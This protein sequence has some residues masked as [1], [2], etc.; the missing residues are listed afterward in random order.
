M[1]GDIPTYANVPKGMDHFTKTEF[2][3]TRQERK[4]QL[5]ALAF[6]YLKATLPDEYH[7]V[8]DMLQGAWLEYEEAATPEAQFMKGMDK[9]EC[10]FQ[11][12]LYE[13]STYGEKD[14]SEFQGLRAKMTSPRT[15]QWADQLQSHRAIDI[16][17]RDRQ[18]PALFVMGTSCVTDFLQSR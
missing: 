7:D 13:K 6:R 16:S 9:L 5:E 18:L 17:R 10:L 3:N 11:A 8:G 15:V 12:G 2:S 4:R 14:L 1:V